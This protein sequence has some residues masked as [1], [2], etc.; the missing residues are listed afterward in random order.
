MASLPPLDIKANGLTPNRRYGGIQEAP[1][2]KWGRGLLV[3]LVLAGNVLVAIF[4]W[5]IAA[6]WVMG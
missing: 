3:A 5:F 6:L 2:S 1:S 4:A